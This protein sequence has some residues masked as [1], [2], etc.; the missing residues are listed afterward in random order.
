MK[1]SIMI[2]AFA[3]VALLGAV[4]VAPQIAQSQPAE[5]QQGTCMVG[6]NSSGV[7]A[8]K[9]V[10]FVGNNTALDDAAWVVRI[11]GET[12]EVFYKNGKKFVRL[13]E[14]E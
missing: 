2:S 3:V 11:N 4:S 12:G 10:F 7:C 9:W 8:G 6:D 14:P 5:P 13:Q 1:K